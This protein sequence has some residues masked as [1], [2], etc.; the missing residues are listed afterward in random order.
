MDEII[1]RDERGGLLVYQLVT[2]PLH[3]YGAAE[4]PERREAYSVMA[5]RLEDGMLSGGTLLCD[6]AADRHTAH[7]IMEL[8][9]RNTVLPED[10]GEIIDDVL[11]SYNQSGTSSA[12]ITHCSNLRAV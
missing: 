5:A 8:L 12:F 2:T 4:L 6:I 1:V 11:A 9:A 10:T 7:G 3:G